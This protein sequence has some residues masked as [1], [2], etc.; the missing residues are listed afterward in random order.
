MVLYLSI[1]I[2]TG[3][4]S[5]VLTIAVN[6]VSFFSLPALAILGM[7]AATIIIEIFYNGMVALLIHCLPKSWFL[8]ER[9]LFKVYKK[10][11]KFYEKIGIKKWKDKVWELGGLGGFRKNKINDPTNPEYLTIFL[12]E[13]NKGIVVHFVSIFIGFLCCLLFPQ[14]FLTIG[15]PASIVGVF[16]NIL[17]I[18]ILRYNIPKLEIAR[19]RA[20]RNKEREE[21]Q[22]SAN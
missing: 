16:L 10:E 2:A 1:I 18:F 14:H 4:F 22:K 17:P 8:A 9:K 11:R 5:T 7:S 6:A 15:L 13:S 12:M 3:I 21:N 20:R 19:E